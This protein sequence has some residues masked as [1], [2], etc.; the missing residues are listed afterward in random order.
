MAGTRVATGQQVGTGK[1]GAKGRDEDKR[2]QVTAILQQVFD[3]TKGDVEKILSGLDKKVDEQFT[4]GRSGRG[5]RFTAE[6]KRGM[7]E[8]KD[9][10]YSGPTGKAPL[11][12][13][14]C[15]P[16]CRTE[17]NRIFDAPATTT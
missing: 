5:T 6:H 3:A 16:G 4:A 17:A 12:A 11:V 8:Y 13:R 15:S 7:D 1:T 9:R 14:T 10:R 2:A